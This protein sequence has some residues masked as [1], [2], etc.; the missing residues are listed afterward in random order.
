MFQP[1]YLYFWRNSTSGNGK[2]T[3]LLY[4][5]YRKTF[6]CRRRKLKCP[7][8]I[9]F[10]SSIEWTHRRHL[11]RRRRIDRK[12]RQMPTEWDLTLAARHISWTS[13]IPRR[14]TPFLLFR[15]S[16]FRTVTKSR[17]CYP[18][19]FSL[20]LSCLVWR[21]WVT[22]SQS[23]VACL[24]VNRWSRLWWLVPDL[25]QIGIQAVRWDSQAPR[26]WDDRNGL[27][28]VECK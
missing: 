13:Y 2:V 23:S 14:S 6:F 4:Q 25:T 27:K 9:R 16:Q 20:R 3:A 7:I 12:R 1:L 22:L 5:K 28:Y 18:T 10:S 8:F 15:L 19:A 24:R 26:R 11:T 21:C 17:G